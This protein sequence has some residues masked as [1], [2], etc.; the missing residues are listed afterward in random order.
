L[1]IDTTGTAHP[2]DSSNPGSVTAT[3]QRGVISI[4]RL[5]SMSLTDR[6]WRNQPDVGIL[7]DE[8]RV[9]DNRFQYADGDAALGCYSPKAAAVASASPST[10]TLPYND[11]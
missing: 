6:L 7:G 5:H 1:L 2:R 8:D 3:L 10:D 11:R 4:L 9:T